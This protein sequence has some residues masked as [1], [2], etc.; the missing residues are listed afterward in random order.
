MIIHNQGIGFTVG[1]REVQKYRIKVPLDAYGL[2]VENVR[3]QLKFYYVLDERYI[4]PLSE[5]EFVLVPTGIFFNGKDIEGMYWG[6]KKFDDGLYVLNVWSR[7]A[8]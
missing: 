3:E 5:L 7:W 6:L 1:L 4:E 2:T 8:K